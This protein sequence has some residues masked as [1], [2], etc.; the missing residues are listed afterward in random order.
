M[1]R[2]VKIVTIDPFK[3]KVTED[4]MG[5]SIEDIYAKINAEC[6]DVVHLRPSCAMYV[7]DTGLYRPDQKFFTITT[8]AYAQPL[9]IGGIAVISG[10]D[11]AGDMCDVHPSIFKMM[12]SDVT[13]RNIRFVGMASDI[14]QHG[15]VTIFNNVPKFEE[16]E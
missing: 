11:S 14:R 3:Q 10:T 9:T 16:V 6:F 5:T 12:V 4:L 15:R 7:D 8:K 13:W 1:A 2:Q